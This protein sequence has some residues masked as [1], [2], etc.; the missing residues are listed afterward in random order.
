MRSS[1]D[2]KTIRPGLASYNFYR[3]DRHPVNR[4]QTAAKPRHRHGGTFIKLVLVLVVAAGLFAG[5][6]AFQN[7]PQKSPASPAAAAQAAAVAAGPGECADNTE[8]KAII[9]SVSK[10]HL[11]ACDKAKVSY[12]AA[13]VTGMEFIP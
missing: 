6:Q 8:T 7:R 5:W 4:R 2:N 1:L 10:R 11:W 9:V 12:D 13:V 3:S